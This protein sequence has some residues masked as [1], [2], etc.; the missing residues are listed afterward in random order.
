MTGKCL[1]EEEFL[2]K[3]DNGEKL[4][5]TDI[6]DIRWNFKIIDEIEGDETR[7]SRCLTLYLKLIIDIL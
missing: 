5:G 1:T 2:R 4:S 3:F 7:W 6:N